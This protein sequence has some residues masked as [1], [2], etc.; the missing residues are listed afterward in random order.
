MSPNRLPRLPGFDY[1]GK[2]TYF[3][4]TC[5]NQRREL[6]DDP[7]NAQPVID[8]FLIV[9]RQFDFEAIAYCAMPDHFHALVR[10]LV[11]DADFRAFMK[12]WKQKSGYQWKQRHG[13]RLWQ[14][15]YHEHVLRTNE[16]PAVF[17]RYIVE[18]PTRIVR[19]GGS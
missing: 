2:Y 13:E 1:R 14:A 5:V 7:A 18:N 6:L 12:A 15:G 19:S 4:T 11:P 16:S 17:V 3:F 9:A 8:Q 10:G